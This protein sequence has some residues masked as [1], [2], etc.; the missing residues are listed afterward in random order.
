MRKEFF[1]NEERHKMRES[2][3]KRN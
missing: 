1:C 3:K 2:S